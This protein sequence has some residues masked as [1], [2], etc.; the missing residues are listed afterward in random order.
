MAEPVAESPGS[1]VALRIYSQGQ[2]V[3]DDRRQIAAMLA[4]PIERVEV[5][6]VSNG[7]GFGGKE[8]MTVQAQTALAAVLCGCP[9]KCTLTREKACAF[10][11][12]AIRCACIS[13][14]RATPTGT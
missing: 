8:D 3:F 12:N 13:A 5:H 1:Q 4:W 7:G 14:L 6:L 9:V 2:G 10:T 11:R